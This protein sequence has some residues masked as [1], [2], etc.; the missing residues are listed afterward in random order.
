MSATPPAHW[1]RRADRSL[2]STRVFEVRGSR[3]AHPQREGDKEF[4]VI[5]APSWVIAAPVTPTGE[6]VM[7][8]QYRF[9]AEELSWELPGGVVE[10]GEAPAAAAVREVVEET[11]YRG[12]NPVELGW[13]YPNPAIQ[14]N[15]AHFVV[16]PQVRQVEATAWDADEELETRLVPLSEVLRMAHAGEIRHALMLN[17]L[18]LLEAW[19]HEH[20][21]I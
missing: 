9:G 12:D 8:R 21:P 6:L 5:D 3:F 19:W 1:Q 16:I 10:D 4:I 15:R 20:G 17:L 13:A 14:S 18:F 11:G 7:V 2:L